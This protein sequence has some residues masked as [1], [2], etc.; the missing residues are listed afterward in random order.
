V[1]TQPI[2]NKSPVR[3]RGQL[4]YA[5]VSSQE[6]FKFLGAPIISRISLEIT[7]Y[8]SKSEWSEQR[9]PFLNFG[10]RTIYMEWAKLDTS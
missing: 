7:R 8:N 3:G 1:A 5:V 2:D 9:D 10:A 6:Q 4:I